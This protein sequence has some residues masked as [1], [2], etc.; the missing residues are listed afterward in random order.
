MS[1]SV[2]FC[3][4]AA[5]ALGHP[6][7]EVLGC[8]ERAPD[9]FFVRLN[10]EPMLSRHVV[11]EDGALVE[12]RGLQAGAAWMKRVG[13]YGWD[14]PD[15]SVLAHALVALDALPAGFTAE[16]ASDKG[17]TS[18][19]L[20]LAPFSFTL[21]RTVTAS[22]SGRSSRT[23]SRGP[24]RTPSTQQRAVLTG[25]ADYR[26]TWTVEQ[27]QASGAWTEVSSTVLEPG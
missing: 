11:V 22:R 25:D 14:S 3:E 21:V 23:S 6:D 7:A 20:S 4:Q 15:P 10:T 18:E 24:G 5:T 19:R 9:C 8:V 12:D 2:P 17:D 26:F 13:I 16:H 27:S 1:P